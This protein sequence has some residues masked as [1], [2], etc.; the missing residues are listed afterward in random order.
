MSS[1]GST[2]PD[3]QGNLSNPDLSP[4]P[5]TFSESPA[6][7]EARN[8]GHRASLRPVSRVSRAALQPLGDSDKTQ[9]GRARSLVQKRLR[10]SGSDATSAGAGSDTTHTC[11]SPSSGVELQPLPIVGVPLATRSLR[12]RE[13]R[14]RTSTRRSL[15][16]PRRCRAVSILRLCLE[17]PPAL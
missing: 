1:Q 15:I 6:E 14:R 12:P 10:I 16:C 17:Y 2:T 4:P 13:N 3:L 11:T 8:P 5:R 7:G 9:R